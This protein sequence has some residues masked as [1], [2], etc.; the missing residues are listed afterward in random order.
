MDTAR[1]DNHAARPRS[2]ESTLSHAPA[3]A[4]VC[5]VHGA[6]LPRW[7]Y[8]LPFFGDPARRHAPDRAQPGY[9]PN[10]ARLSR[11]CL[12]AARPSAPVALAGGRGAALGERLG[13]DYWACGNCDRPDF[14]ADDATVGAVRA[15][16]CG[17]APPKRIA[18]SPSRLPR[19]WARR[20]PGRPAVAARHGG[21]LVLEG[22]RRR[23]VASGAPRGRW[24]YRD[25]R[26]RSTRVCRAGRMWPRG[27]ACL[28][29]SPV[30]PT[31]VRPL[32]GQHHPHRSPNRTRC[33]TAQCTGAPSRWDC[34]SQGPRLDD[35][36]LLAGRLD[37]VGGDRQRADFALGRSSAEVRRGL[38]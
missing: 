20:Q 26:V 28:G 22:L 15:R 3:S 17:A 34:G 2:T 13:R 21:T 37:E 4:P 9:W 36:S 11:P 33:S 18:C 10:A 23:P 19:G 1:G 24:R 31:V 7:V 29:L 5:G 27:L 6:W 16:E 32:L 14:D 38:G 30:P 25:R 35:P 8:C 12:A